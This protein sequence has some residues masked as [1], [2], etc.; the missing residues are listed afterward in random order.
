MMVQCKFQSTAWARAT[1]SAVTPSA[2]LGQNALMLMP[3]LSERRVACLSGKDRHCCPLQKEAELERVPDQARVH[4][5][6]LHAPLRD[7]LD[8]AFGLEPRNEFPDGSKRQASQLD[9]LAL[10]D[11]LPRADVSRQE[12]VRKTVVGFLPKLVPSPRLTQ[13]PPSLAS[14]S[15]RFRRRDDHRTSPSRSA[16]RSRYPEERR[17]TFSQAASP[18]R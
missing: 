1:R 12:M 5:S 17:L 11:E 9:K 8:E 3:K 18:V 16:F 4:M 15:C 13:P 14:L 10:R 7:G 2:I 6:N